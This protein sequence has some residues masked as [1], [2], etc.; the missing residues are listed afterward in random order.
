MARNKQLQITLKRSTNGKLSVH[1]A[2]V[3]GL[4]LHRLGQTVV[5]K[6]TPENLGMIK[7]VNYLLTVEAG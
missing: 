3:A 2:C 7:K 4:G 5:V 6:A 1:K